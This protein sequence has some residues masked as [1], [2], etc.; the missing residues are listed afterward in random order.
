M[1][2]ALIRTNRQYLY[3]T[4]RERLYAVL[5]LREVGL[6]QDLCHGGPT[7]GER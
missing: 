4:T 7:S 1:V 5:R 2:P 6:L 3:S